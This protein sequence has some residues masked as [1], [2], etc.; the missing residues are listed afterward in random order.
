MGTV[1]QARDLLEGKPV[2]VKT[3]RDTYRFAS[4]AALLSSLAHPGIVRYLA[5]GVTT[6][7]ERYLVM[8]WLEG[9]TLEQRLTRRPLSIA[10][11]VA[12]AL[13]TCEALSIAH[14]RGIVHRD[15]KPSNL[16]LEQSAPLRVKILDFGLA[17]RLSDERLTGSGV[18]VGTLGYMAPEQARG[19]NQ[20]DARA[21]VFSLGCVLYECLTGQPAFW[22]ENDMAVLAKILLS[23]PPSPRDL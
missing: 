23:E 5:H 16:F 14:E 19:S 2:A 9:E 15:L 13:R 6:Q 8:E 22:G 12:L 7:G 4:E 17:R 3:L 11:S 18:I 1:Y 10:G 21:D 20:L